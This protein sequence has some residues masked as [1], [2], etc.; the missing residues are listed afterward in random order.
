MFGG[1]VVLVPLAYRK[2]NLKFK[3]VYGGLFFERETT[4]VVSDETF[5]LTLEL[6]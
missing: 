3:V 6:C 1:L 4:H 2:L 5:V